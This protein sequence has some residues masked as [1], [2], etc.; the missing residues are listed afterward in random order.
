MRNIEKNAKKVS[1]RTGVPVDLACK[2]SR[3]GTIMTS[4]ATLAVGGA[5]GAAA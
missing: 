4:A 2:V 1:K 5:V 3:P